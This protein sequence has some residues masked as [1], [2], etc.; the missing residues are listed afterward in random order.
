M[1]Y[2]STRSGRCAGVRLAD[3]IGTTARVGQR[4]TTDPCRQTPDR[5]LSLRSEESSLNGPR[6]DH[7]ASRYAPV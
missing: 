4:F 6:V 5:R 3:P 2:S 7:D 1:K